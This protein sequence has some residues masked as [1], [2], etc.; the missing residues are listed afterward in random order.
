MNIRAIDWNEA[1][2]RQQSRNFDD[3][4]NRS[5]W[6]KRAPSFA[7]SAGNS[8]YV[9]QFLQLLELEPDWRVLDVGCAAGT[10][11]IP[12]ATQVRQVTGVDISPVM[13]DCL[14]GRCGEQGIDNIRTVHASWG[15]DWDQAGIIPH[16]VAIASRSLVVPD[17]RAA[18]E[19][20]NRFATRR[21]YISTPA[22]GGPLDRAMFQAIGRPFR[23]G[24]D[25]IYVYNLL[26]QMGVHANLRFITYQENKTYPDQEAVLKSLRGK[27]GE[28][29][30][31][32]EQTL[33]DYV[34]RC[35]VCCQGRWQ[36]A[37]PRIVRWAVMWWDREP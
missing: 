4:C 28:L 37:E 33:R 20:L 18:I 19:N 15:D 11:A 3:G 32:E 16:E 35:F 6:D 26:Y 29:L 8:P 2:K 10:L 25:Y 21:V 7:R 24:A 31:Q 12:L 17:L 22:G 1:W 13:L 27:I 34:E 36:R 9:E 14:Q 23:S 5:Y 30:P